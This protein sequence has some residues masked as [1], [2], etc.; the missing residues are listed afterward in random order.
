[1][2]VTGRER[3]LT[4]RLICER[5]MLEH[6][7]EITVLATDPRVAAT[8]YADG[9][10]LDE[11]QISLGLTLKVRHWEQH[12]FGDWLLRDRGT[13][14]L[15]GRGGLQWTRVEGEPEVEVGYALRPERWGEGLATELAQQSVTTAF[16]DLGLAEIVA[17]TLPHNVASR[18]VMEKAGFGFERNIVHAGLP[19]VLYR[20]RP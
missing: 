17:F 10:P 20:R 5:I 4:P 12:G 1:M 13:G 3:V 16:D 6:T 11:A 2:K 19:H 8:L 9:Q 15:V 7:P 14:A 18:R